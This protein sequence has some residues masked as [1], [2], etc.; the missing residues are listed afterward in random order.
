MRR[1]RGAEARQ[2]QP[3]PN[4]TFWVPHAPGARVVRDPSYAS[5]ALRAQALQNQP[6]IGHDLLGMKVLSC[7]EGVLR[8]GRVVVDN[9]A[10]PQGRSVSQRSRVPA[11]HNRS[12]TSTLRPE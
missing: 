2:F 7:S 5:H 3:W 4:A 9:S 12:A 1:M 11:H 8:V 6:C 10:E